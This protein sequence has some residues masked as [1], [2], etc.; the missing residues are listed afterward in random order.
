[1]S[2][3]TAAALLDTAEGFTLAP[4]ETSDRIDPDLPHNR[5]LIES[6]RLVETNDEQPVTKADL[7]EEAKA[8]DISGRSKM[9]ASE[10]QAA[11]DEA[12]ASDQGESD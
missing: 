8:L 4:G 7:L 5:R 9:T 10:L 2:T 1:M 11:I 6:G 3:F 12:K